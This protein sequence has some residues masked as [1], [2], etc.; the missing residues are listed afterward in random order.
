VA[1]SEVQSWAENPV[2]ALIRST[3]VGF[4]FFSDPDGIARGRCSRSP[5]RVNR[6]AILE[7]W[8][9]RKARKSGS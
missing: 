2:R 9:A 8:L 3:N 1:V 4:V 6:P 5:P 7:L